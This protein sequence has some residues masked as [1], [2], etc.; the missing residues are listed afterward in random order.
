MACETAPREA[1]QRSAEGQSSLRIRAFTCCTKQRRHQPLRRIAT[2][3]PPFYLPPARVPRVLLGGGEG[4]CDTRTPPRGRTTACLRR[5]I[6]SSSTRRPISIP[7]LKF[8]VMCFAPFLRDVQG[9]AADA[10]DAA[11][12]TE[13]AAP[14]VASSQQQCVDKQGRSCLSGRDSMPP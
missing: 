1:L 3:Q 14:T 8:A 11:A 13:V 7:F 9:I 10:S 5:A 4:R 2:P 12:G 6:I